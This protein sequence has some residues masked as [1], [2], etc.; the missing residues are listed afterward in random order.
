M[1]R[2]RVCAVEELPPGKATCVRHEKEGIAV[3]NMNGALHACDD[4]CPHAGG[5]LHMGFVHGTE[6]SCPWHGWTF[7][8]AETGGPA[9]GVRRYPV[10][11]EDGV[12][13]VEVPESASE[14]KL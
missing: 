10:A 12:V 6:V 7:D 14:G 1:A 3:F 4:A 13:Y 5:S 9:D 11:V 8:L 2:V